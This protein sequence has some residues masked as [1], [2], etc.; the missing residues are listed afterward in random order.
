MGELWGGP[1][2]KRWDLKGPTIRISQHPE[3]SAYFAT[4]ADGRRALVRRARN[5]SEDL[6]LY[7]L[8]DTP[9]LVTLPKFGRGVSTAVVSSDA[10]WAATADYE[11]DLFVWSLDRA[12]DP[13]PQ[14]A[15]TSWHDMKFVGFSTSG[16]SA[17]FKTADAA[18]IIDIETGAAVH[19]VVIPEIWRDTP[20]SES[21]TPHSDIRGGTMRRVGTRLKSRKKTSANDYPVDDF[22]RSRGHTATVNDRRRAPNGRWE[23]TVSHDGTA[24]VWELA[25]DRP[26]ATFASEWGLDECHWSPDSRTLVVID[27]ARR[28]HLL[29]L[30]GV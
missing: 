2:L 18:T 4:S 20:E 16:R 22:G 9:R 5:G 28:T 7:E 11:H 23:V 27:S 8:G 25:G 3:I 15:P 10:R 21:P 14:P 17:V 1:A 13:L 19:N 26:L 12:L 30:E 6:A 24:R 29:R